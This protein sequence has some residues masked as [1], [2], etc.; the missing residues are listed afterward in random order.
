M[1]QAHI[2]PVSPL[3][4][5]F[6]VSLSCHRGGTDRLNFTYKYSLSTAKTVTLAI[7]QGAVWT[8]VFTRS[9]SA[10]GTKTYLWDG[11]IGGVFLPV[12][13]YTV[14]LSCLAQ[15]ASITV[16]IL[17][18]PQLSITA[19][20]P[21]TFTADGVCQQKVSIRWT[22]L[23][24]VRLD[25][26]TTAGVFVKCIYSAKNKP[27]ASLQLGWNGRN[28][29]NKLLPSGTYQYRLIC[30]GAAPLYMTVT[31][32]AAMSADELYMMDLVNQSRKSAGLKPLVFNRALRTGALAHSKDM[33]AH[34][35]FGHR[36]PSYGDL[37]LRMHQAGISYLSA[38]ENLALSNSISRVYQSLMA[39]PRH[40]ANILGRTYG[41]IGIGIVWN[42]SRSQYY[43]TQWF[44][45]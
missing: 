15:T 32:K 18:K 36:S 14:R 34:V 20:T 39:S 12:G 2:F 11:K 22:H 4:Q 37:P 7:K 6:R 13:S 17:E 28:A 30:G 24:D 42:A 16:R 8:T 44:T 40:R 9:E 25:V 23:S 5:P 19:V 45:N 3:R 27:V 38:G 26:F 29:A 35:F 41:H 10:P 1:P 33:S 21:L 43:I 31:L